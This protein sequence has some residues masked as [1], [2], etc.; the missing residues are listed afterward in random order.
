MRAIDLA[1]KLLEHPNMKVGIRK[2]SGDNRWLVNEVSVEEWDDSCDSISLIAGDQNGKFLL[3][4]AL[5]E[6]ID[7]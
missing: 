2:F 5:E 1:K 7:D 3:L 4:D 6:K